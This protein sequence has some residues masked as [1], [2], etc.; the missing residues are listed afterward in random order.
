M[1]KLFLALA[2][3]TLTAGIAGPSFAGSCAGV[4]T[5]ACRDAREAFAE[6]H[7]GVYPQQYYNQWYNGRQG[8][9]AQ[10]DRDWRWEGMN[11][12]DYWRE[13]N[14]WKWHKRDHGDWW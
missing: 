9:W 14:E 7:G 10:R 2:L 13:K 5:K 11:G 6:H 8:R 4:N 3:G 1:K 12:N